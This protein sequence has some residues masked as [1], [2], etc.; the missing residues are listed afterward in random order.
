MYWHTQLEIPRV[1]AS[2]TARSRGLNN[3]IMIWCLAIFR[4][5]FFS[6]Y[7]Q[8]GSLNLMMP[9]VSRLTVTSSANPRG[10]K[11]ASFPVV[12]IETPTLILTESTLVMSE[13]PRQ[14]V[15]LTSVNWTENGR[16]GDSLKENLSAVSKIIIIIIADN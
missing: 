5:I 14:E 9:S 4:L 11:S 3:V 7:P 1:L 15:R 13:E 8:S 16:D 10:N 12:H 6:E 2:G